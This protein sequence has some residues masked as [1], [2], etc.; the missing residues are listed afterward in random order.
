MADTYKTIDGRT[1]TDRNTAQNHAN[2]LANNIAID[3]A[4][5]AQIENTLRRE[6]AEKQ[7]EAYKLITQDFDNGNWNAVINGIK[8]ANEEWKTYTF[9]FNTVYPHAYM[10]EYIAEANINSD[11]EKAFATGKW[12]KPYNGEDY[13]TKR[14]TWDFFHRIAMDTGKRLWEKKYGRTITD[15]DINQLR[16]EHEKNTN[17]KRKMRQREE[18]VSSAKGFINSFVS[19]IFGIVCGAGVL[20][21]SVWILVLITGKITSGLLILGLLAVGIFSGIVAGKAFSNKKNLVF[22]LILSLSIVGWLSLFGL[23]PNSLKSVFQE[24]T[25]EQTTE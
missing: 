16:I 7:F 17:N 13:P 12:G 18:A 25:T 3:S 1:F 2:D 23:L 10:M 9:P 4:R 11:Y 14:K 24:A 15:A 19:I 20:L 21:T 22:I 8:A 6:M 5:S